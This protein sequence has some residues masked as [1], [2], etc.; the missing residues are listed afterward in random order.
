MTKTAVVIGANRGIGLQLIK[1]LQKHGYTCTGTVRPS[2]LTAH[3]TRSQAPSSSSSHTTSTSASETPAADDNNDV[4]TSIADLEAT[5]ARILTLDYLDPASIDHAATT[6]GVSTTPLD[7]LVN[8]AGV[9]PLPI[10]WRDAYPAAMAMQYGTMC[11]G[12]FLATRAFMPALERA[13]GLAKVLNV[14]S[15]FG[16]IAD[17]NGGWI[18]YRSAKAGLNMVTKTLAEEFKTAGLDVVLAAVNPGFIR[19]RLSGWHPEAT[20]DVEVTC[21]G[22]LKVVDALST[23]NSGGFWDWDGKRFSW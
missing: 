2:T 6:W 3:K 16:S 5:G 1:T 23:D 15:D 9:S 4:D 21:E 13:A 18:G 11:I 10:P 14:S 19:T 20:D 17:S 8:C 22:M 12:P 7:L